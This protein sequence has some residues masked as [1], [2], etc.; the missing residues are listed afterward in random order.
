MD[1]LKIYLNMML[2]IGYPLHIHHKQGFYDLHNGGAEKSKNLDEKN[3]VKRSLV[4]WMQE[5]RQS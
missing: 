3:H 5:S 1:I 2:S 4:L